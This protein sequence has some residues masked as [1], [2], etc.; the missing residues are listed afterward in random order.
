MIK[1]QHEP[2]ISLETAKAI[3]YRLHGNKNKPVKVRKDY[4]ENFPLRGIA[5]CPQC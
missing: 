1:A 2:I 5:Y 4:N 3:M